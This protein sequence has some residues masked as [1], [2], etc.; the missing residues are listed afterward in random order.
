MKF[1]LKSLLTLKWLPICCRKQKLRLRVN[2]LKWAANMY[3]AKVY[4]TRAGEA[5]GNPAYWQ[6]AWDEAIKVYGKYSV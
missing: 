4:M 6:N 3:L 1:M 2:L 5:G